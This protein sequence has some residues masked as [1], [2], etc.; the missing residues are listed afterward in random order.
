MCLLDELIEIDDQQAIAAVTPKPGDLFVTDDGVP[1]L[2]GIEY[3]AQTVASFSCARANKAGHP[4][5]GLLLGSRRY[6]SE[7]AFFPLGEK[8]TVIV[9]PLYLEDDA[10]GVF[11]GKIQLGDK[12]VVNA[13][14]NVFQPDDISKHF[15]PDSL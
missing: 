9:K 11:E 4:D 3:I 1:A 12:V 13:T 10:L 14:L 7:V 6:T 5:I 15:T 2:V 8:L